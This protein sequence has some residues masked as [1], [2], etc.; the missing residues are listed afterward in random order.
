MEQLF[1]IIRIETSMDMGIGNRRKQ[2]TSIA[3]DD[4]VAGNVFDIYGRELTIVD[5]NENEMTFN[6]WDKNDF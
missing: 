5:V 3:D 4:L 6:Y 2:W 1:N